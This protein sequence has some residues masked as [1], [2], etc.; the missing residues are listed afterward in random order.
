LKVLL[1]KLGDGTVTFSIK[2]CGGCR[3]GV[4]EMFKM[5]VADIGYE[6]MIF[7]IMQNKD[8]KIKFEEL[9]I[10]CPNCDEKMK[11]VTY[12][13]L[14]EDDIKLLNDTPLSKVW[15]SLS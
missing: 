1:N 5:N 12:L 13:Q 11:D 4:I 7:S 3:E 10:V 9:K 6:N 14:T 2:R 15:V 8:L